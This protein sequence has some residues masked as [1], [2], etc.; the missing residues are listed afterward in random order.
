[1]KNVSTGNAATPTSAAVATACLVAAAACGIV[2][3][4]TRAM[5]RMTVAL[6]III[7]SASAPP[8]L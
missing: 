7:S 2:I 5:S 3:N 1:V 6:A 4:S 8:T